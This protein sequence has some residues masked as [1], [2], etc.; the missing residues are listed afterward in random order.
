M[1]CIVFSSEITQDIA[2]KGLGI[3]Y[4][5]CS[6]EQKD[7]LVVMLV[8]TLTTGKKSVQQEVTGDTEVFQEGSIGKTPDG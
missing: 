6:K 3:V 2:S 4:E 1:S 8:D 5:K 7:G